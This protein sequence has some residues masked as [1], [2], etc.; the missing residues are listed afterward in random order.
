MDAAIKK[1]KLTFAGVPPIDLTANPASLGGYLATSI[2]VGQENAIKAELSPAA[3]MAELDFAQQQAVTRGYLRHV[4]SKLDKVNP[5]TAIILEGL[6]GAIRSQDLVSVEEFSPELAS[7]LSIYNKNPKSFEDYTEFSK[8]FLQGQI[9]VS[10]S[11]STLA[12]SQADAEIAASVRKFSAGTPDATTSIYNSVT[13]VAAKET[14]AR[15]IRDQVSNLRGQAV[16]SVEPAVTATLNDRAKAME[17]SLTDGLISSLVRGKTPDDVTRIREAVADNNR[18]N[19]SFEE[20]YAFSVLTKN[21]SPEIRDHIDSQL[22]EYAAGPAKFAE[23]RQR[24]AAVSY[25]QELKTE[26]PILATMRDI[27]KIQGATNEL[28]AAVGSAVGLPDGDANKAKDD[29]YAQGANAALNLAIKTA[30]SVEAMTEMQDY[31][32]SGEIGNLSVEVRSYLDTFVRFGGLVSDNGFRDGQFNSAKELRK[33]QLT[34]AADARV[35]SD[36]IKNVS[37]GRGDALTEQ[38][39]TAASD[40]TLGLI[41]RYGSAIDRPALAKAPADLWRNPTYMQDPQYSKVFADVYKTAGAMPV[42]LLRELETF[43][44]GVDSPTALA[45]YNAMKVL[46]TPDGFVPNPALMA[47]DE[48]ERGRLDFYSEVSRLTDTKISIASLTAAANKNMS[49]EGFSKT[50]SMFL[51]A[52]EEKPLNDWMVESIDDYQLLNPA[53][54]ESVKSLVTFLVA[55][56]LAGGPAQQTPKSIA[57]KINDQMNGWFP[58]GE[59]Y[60]IDMS[61]GLPSSR[62]KF[63]LSQ[64]IGPYKAEFLSFATSEYRRLFPDAPAKDFLTPTG[65]GI[66]ADLGRTA[67]YMAEGVGAKVVPYMQ[68]VPRGKDRFGGVTYMVV[69]IDP[70]TGSIP[71]PIMLPSG[72]PF[73]VST[74]EPD[75]MAITNSIAADKQLLTDQQEAARK[76]ILDLQSGEMPIATLG[77]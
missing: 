44:A 12:K 50:V 48:N 16:A 74:N 6:N 22:S 33:A 68:F 55:D 63:A 32:R 42:E 59:G 52:G 35:R 2:K 51:G 13:S 37:A 23:T 66:L 34:Q 9:A 41:N 76:E 73:M 28:I 4:V 17:L 67:K 49:K 46:S 10:K 8:E 3:S 26:L 5:D 54:Q 53:Q 29:I 38:G 30:G 27:T 70:E 47:L 65:T 71:Q 72:E 39:Q 56:T 45:H 60:V 20:S 58:S 77:N 7:L 14:F 1:P 19:L 11:S 18:R 25:A 69:S 31:A 36:N 15:G 24:E 43:A 64:T 61:N 21:A 40:W 62:T 57:R 75:F